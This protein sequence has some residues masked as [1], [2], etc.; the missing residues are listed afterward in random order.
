MVKD[1]LEA[2]SKKYLITSK[3]DGYFDAKQQQ[4]K[5]HPKR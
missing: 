5:V 4:M 1:E 3:N 2:L